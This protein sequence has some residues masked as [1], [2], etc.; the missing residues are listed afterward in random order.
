MAQGTRIIR[1]SVDLAD[2][3]RNQ[4]ERLRL[5]LAW[6]PS[7]TAHR[8]VARLLAYLACYDPRLKFTRGVSAGKEPDLW[9]LDG[10]GRAIEWIEVGTPDAERLLKQSRGADR[11]LVFLYGDRRG[12]WRERE[13]AS[14]STRTGFALLVLEDALLA[15]L[16]EG[17]G[18]AIEWNCT[19]AGA[20]MYLEDRGRT[21][22][23]SLL[24]E[25][26]DPLTGLSGV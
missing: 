25:L 14:L 3:D 5:S 1:A 9:R 20:T 7:E 8:L 21:H 15:A 18:K 22:E 2:S 17:L 6:H 24:P 4:Y 10:D 23:I 19:I 11:L 26:G 13:L 16:S 12:N